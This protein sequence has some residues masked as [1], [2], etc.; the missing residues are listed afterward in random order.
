[1]KVV[2]TTLELLFK[3][4]YLKTSLEEAIILTSQHCKEELPVTDF[5]VSENIVGD[6]YSNLFKEYNVK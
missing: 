4:G 2:S 6:F 1:M 3:E 5:K